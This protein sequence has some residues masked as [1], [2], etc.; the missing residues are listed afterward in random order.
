MKNTIKT[1]GSLK[2]HSGAI[3]TDVMR[4]KMGEVLD[5]VY[6]R[7]DEFIIERK[8]KPMAVLISLEKYKS[9]NRMAK[10]SILNIYKQHN[11]SAISENEADLLANEA[12]H[13]TRNNK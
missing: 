12:K 2:L 13:L 4:K 11:N 3:G 7:G 1:A 6:L 8:N 9:L 10:D 5:C